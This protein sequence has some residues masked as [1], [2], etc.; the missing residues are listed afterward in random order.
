MSQDAAEVR[1]SRTA[2][3]DLAAELACGEGQGV[4]QSE[5][6]EALPERTPVALFVALTR[7]VREAA[8]PADMRSQAYE[9][10]DR[11]AGSVG[12]PGFAAAL[13]ALTAFAALEP[14]LLA[15]LK[16][17]WPELRSLSSIASLSERE[18]SKRR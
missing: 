8:V 10:M 17:F 2:G 4:L 16:P 1:R 18:T 15:T 9:R 6:M 14:R 12:T 13:E 5:S 11:M 7:A 3:S